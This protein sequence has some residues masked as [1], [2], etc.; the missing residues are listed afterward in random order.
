MTFDLHGN[1]SLNNT[2]VNISGINLSSKG[3]DMPFEGT[4][5]IKISNGSYLQINSY[6]ALL[7]GATVTIE[8]GASTTITS[9]GRVTAFDPY[10]YITDGHI[11]NYPETSQS[12]YREAPVFDFNNDT[13][14]VMTVNGS[15]SIEAGGAIAG[16][17]RTGENGIIMLDNNAITKYDINYVEDNARVASRE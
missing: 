11:K 5:N 12:Y 13:P 17:V 4:W 16:R 6:V 8:E 2:N 15:L 7:P 10:K 9:E 1:A 3:K 14:A